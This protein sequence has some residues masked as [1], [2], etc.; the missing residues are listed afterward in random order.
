MGWMKPYNCDTPPEFVH[1]QAAF[2]GGV[3][4]CPRHPSAHRVPPQQKKWELVGFDGIDPMI[5]PLRQGT[6]ICLHFG[7]SPQKAVLFCCLVLEEG[8]DLY[9]YIYIILLFA[10]PILWSHTHMVCYCPGKW[11]AISVKVA[12]QFLSFGPMPISPR[13]KSGL[14]V[15]FRPILSHKHLKCSLNN[16]RPPATF[17]RGSKIATPHGTLASGNMDQNLRSNSWWFN[18]DPYPFG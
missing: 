13:R 8:P 18:F 6:T 10:R 11:L 3:Q 12:V 15:L 4:N 7:G 5:P 17:G 2:L 14:S 9:I 1:P 16:P